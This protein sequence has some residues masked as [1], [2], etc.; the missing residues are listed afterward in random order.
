MNILALISGGFHTVVGANAGL[1][2]Y[3]IAA[4]VGGFLPNLTAIFQQA[5]WSDRRRAIVGALIAILTGFVVSVSH[6]AYTGQTIIGCVFVTIG[7]SWTSY[8]N[9]WKPTDIAPK[10]ERITTQAVGGFAEAFRRGAALAVTD[11]PAPAPA[12]PLVP[13]PSA[14]TGAGTAV[15]TVPSG[16]PGA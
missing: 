1:N 8:K 2:L 9:L 6:G 3:E 10:I 12:A 5:A 16:Q 14:A 13:A 15:D 11:A 4:V 7:A